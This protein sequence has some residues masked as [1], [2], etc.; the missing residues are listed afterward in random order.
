MAG[1][2]WTVA[3][4]IKLLLYSNIFLNKLYSMQSILL[5]DSIYSLMNIF[6]KQILQLWRQ[7][8][9]IR[10][11]I[12][13]KLNIHQRLNVKHLISILRYSSRVSTN[14][15]LFNQWLVGM[16]DGDGTFSI[17]RQ[18]NTWALTYKPLFLFTFL[19]FI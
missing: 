14:Q 18:N 12:I 19:I 11:V 3:I 16:T 9:W 5:I 1:T 4:I 13:N 7:F 17:V 2:G 10:F 6:I 8:A 15:D